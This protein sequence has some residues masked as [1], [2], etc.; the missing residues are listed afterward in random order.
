MWGAVAGAL[1]AGSVRVLG[2][3]QRPVINTLLKKRSLQLVNVCV[4]R[5]NGKDSAIGQ[6]LGV[7]PEQTPNEHLI[8]KYTVP[9]PFDKGEN[10]SLLLHKPDQPENPKV[11]RVV[12]LGAP[13]AGKSTLSNKLL[14]RKVFPVSKKVHTTRCQGQ[15][16]LTDGETQLILLDTPGMVNNT[17]VKRHHLE[18]SLQK[19]PWD[20]MKLADVV[21]ILVDAS[22]MWTRHSLHTEVLKCLFQYPTIPSILVMNKVDL[23]K[24]KG[25]LLEIT[26]QLTEGIVNNKKAVIKPL[27]KPL[28]GHGDNTGHTSQGQDTSPFEIE[29]PGVTVN[30]PVSVKLSPDVDEF[31]DEESDA[32]RRKIINELKKRKGWPH[33]RDVFMLSAINGEEVETLKKYLLTLAKPGEWE[34]HSDVVTT[35]SP[36]EICNNIIREKLLEYLPQEVPYNVTQVTDLWEEGSCGELVIMQTLLVQKE[37]H[38]KI[39]IGRGGQLVSKIAQE[40]GKDLMDLFLCDVRLRLSVKFKK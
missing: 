16:V 7:N 33:F 38:V 40:A 2:Q 24:Q 4:T 11:L 28:P 30:E 8:Q 29:E 19:D 18:K 23:V 14:G 32:A 35:Q 9:V 21:L 1:R 12:I 25:I 26:K 20:C 13:N 17:K 15:G 22:D 39:L 34:Y 31:A 36:Q 27:V 10:D 37:N 3:Q 6:L 5:F